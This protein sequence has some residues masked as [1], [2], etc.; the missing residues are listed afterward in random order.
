MDLKELINVFENTQTHKESI[1]NITD[2]LLKIQTALDEI[3]NTLADALPLLLKE[4]RHTVLNEH[5]QKYDILKNYITEIQES[6]NA[7]DKIETIASNVAND[8]PK[9]ATV[10]TNITEAST[11]EPDYEIKW[12]ELTR[13]QDKAT[14][15]PACKSNLSLKNTY[16]SVFTDETKTYK[17]PKRETITRYC[18]VCKTLYLEENG[19]RKIAKDIGFERTNIKMMGVCLQPDCY[20]AVYRGN[21]C[22]FHYNYEHSS[23]K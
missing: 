23:S 1:E 8:I 22:R 10:E 7:F 18:A 3:A 16:F 13:L 5:I 9:P 20:D 6:I 11:T 4:G 19:I 17:E 14:K 15:C 21:Y 12:I 2:G